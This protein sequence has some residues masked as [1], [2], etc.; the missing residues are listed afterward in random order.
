MNGRRH[1][2]ECGAAFNYRTKKDQPAPELCG[3][4]ACHARRHW[5]P[6]D[7]AGRARMAAARAA[8]DVPLDALD[9]EALS[10]AESRP[11]ADRDAA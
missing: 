7:W 2:D 3:M 1:C 11:R 5:G 9:R 6:E 4:L 10:R 8:A